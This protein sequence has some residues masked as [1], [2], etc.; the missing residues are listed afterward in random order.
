MGSLS[1]QKLGLE[2]LTLGHLYSKHLEYYWNDRLITRES[3]MAVVIILSHGADNGRIVCS[4]GLM[5]DIEEDVYKLVLR[6]I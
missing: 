1:V 3:D 6:R 4:D 2:Y 5:I